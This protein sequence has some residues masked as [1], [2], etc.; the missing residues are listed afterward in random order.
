M[1]TS[2]WRLSERKFTA[3][4]PSIPFVTSAWVLGS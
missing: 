2:R 3:T 1:L 4:A